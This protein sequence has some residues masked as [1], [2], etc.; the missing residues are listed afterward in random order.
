MSKRP[1]FVFYDGDCG[2]C[3]RFVSFLVRRDRSGQLFRYA[4]LCG[5]TF[6]SH[7][8]DADRDGLPDSI[9]VLTHE[10]SLLVRSAGAIATLRRLGGVWRIIASLARIVPRPLADLLYDAIARWRL[11]LFRRPESTC[12]ILPAELR[13]RFLP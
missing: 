7:V 10:G 12:P 3:H 5:E 11:S 13:S 9:V 2:L 6:A 1:W 8:P 4:P